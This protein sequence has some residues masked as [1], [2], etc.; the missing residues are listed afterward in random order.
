MAS[1]GQ[2]SMVIYAIAL[3]TSD[4]SPA[5]GMHCLFKNRLK[6]HLQRRGYIDT[7]DE[8]SYIII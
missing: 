5:Q 7:E 6:D 8:N 4:V 1:V 3:T 2:L